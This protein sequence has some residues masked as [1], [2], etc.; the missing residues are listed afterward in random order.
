MPLTT[1]S[2]LGSYEILSLLGAGGMGEVYRARDTRLKREVAIKVLPESFSHDPERLARFQR[3]AE[4]L[5]TLN[6]PNI[7]AIYGLEQSH[8]VS[9]IVMELVEGETL[10]ERLAGVAE[11]LSH[12]GRALPGPPG[13]PDLI[14][15]GPRTAGLLVEDAI[16]KYWIIDYV[17]GSASI[18]GAREDL[19]LIDR[20]GAVEPLRLP[21]GAYQF[22]RVSPDGKLVALGTNDGKEEI[23][24][25]Y[26]LAGTTAM[27][28]LTFG[29]KNRF[30]LWSSDAERVA[31][32]SDREGDLGIFWQRAD[33]TGTAERL[34]KPDQGTSHVPESWSPKG[35]QFLFSVTKGSTNALWMFS[36]QDKKTTPFDDVRSSRRKGALLHP[37]DRWIRGRECDHAADFRLR[38]F[39]DG[40]KSVCERS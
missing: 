7:A 17:P 20:K 33:G 29:G 4:L 1:G 27:R 24:W 5:A 37:P 23:V 31:F 39:S 14:R 16:L 25:I 19:A 3:E 40:A 9:A 21:S 36:L 30:P 12:V 11:R 28:R 8:G 32:Q 2:R 15:S 26:D 6:H 38:E 22:P 18:A 13:K 10:A 34:T 35:E